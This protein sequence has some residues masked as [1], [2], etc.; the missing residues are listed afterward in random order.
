M[1]WTKGQSGN[2]AGR[3]KGARDKLSDAMY[4]EA[5][6]HWGNHGPAALDKVVEE[7]PARYLQFMAQILPKSHD[8]SIDDTR[9]AIDEYSAEELAAMIGP[10]SKVA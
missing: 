1:P 6:E 4:E 10:T 8:V 9:R 5:V 2:P 7:S 3:P